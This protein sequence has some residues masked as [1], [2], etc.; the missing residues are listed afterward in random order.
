MTDLYLVKVIH[1]CSV[2]NGGGSVPNP[3]WKIVDEKLAQ[4][5][6]E[7]VESLSQALEQIERETWPK[8]SPPPRHIRCPSC[9]G[10]GSSE[11][12]TSLGYAMMQRSKRSYDEKMEVSDQLERMG[13]VPAHQPPEPDST[14]LRELDL[15]MRLYNLLK[16]NGIDTVDR[17][18]EQMPRGP[19]AFLVLRAFGPK[20]LGD[21]VRALIETGRWTPNGFPEWEQWITRHE[22]E[23]GL[24]EPDP[25]SR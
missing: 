1:I 3:E 4:A 20:S 25:T 23:V 22:G 6:Q 18:L 21:L 19:D 17:V 12:W 11:A 5:A 10:L 2:C 13:F 16:R 7:H 14:D 15:S 24:I 9:K 8:H